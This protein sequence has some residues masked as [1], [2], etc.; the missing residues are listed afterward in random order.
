MYSSWHF[1]S[2]D[3]GSSTVK[4]LQ[5]VNQ[6]PLVATW[7]PSVLVWLHWHHKL[8]YFHWQHPSAS[9]KGGSGQ[10]T[11]SKRMTYPL[12]TWYKLLRTNKAQDSERFDLQWT[13]SSLYT[14]CN[15]LAVKWYAHSCHGSSPRP[16]IKVQKVGAGPVPGNP[17]PFPKKLE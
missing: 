9:G 10:G 16:T 7:H 12:R 3:L 6:N 4:F 1:T 13:L 2:F 11:T 14:H 15:T 17:C 8:S 5:I